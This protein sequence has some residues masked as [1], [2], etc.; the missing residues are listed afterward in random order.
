M[1]DLTRECRWCGALFRVEHANCAALYCKRTHKLAAEKARRRMR[2]AGIQPCPQPWS[3]SEPYRGLA[4][5]AA[6][7]LG[8]RAA[9]CVCG[10]YHPGPV[11]P[12]GPTA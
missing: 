11:E 9:E 12:E 3:D 5:N 1:K 10:N 2:A 7:R 6:R 4:I 8:T